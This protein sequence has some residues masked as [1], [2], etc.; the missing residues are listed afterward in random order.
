[1]SLYI[2]FD[3]I[4]Q[5][6]H[7][8][9]PKNLILFLNFIFGTESKK[10]QFFWN[11]IGCWAHTNTVDLSRWRINLRSIPLVFSKRQRR[12]GDLNQYYWKFSDFV[13]NCWNLESK[14][15]VQNHGSFAGLMPVLEFHSTKWIRVNDSQL[16][17]LRSEER[18]MLLLFS[19][20]QKPQT[21]FGN[22]LHGN[23][24]ACHLDIP[25]KSKVWHLLF[26]IVKDIF[27]QTKPQAAFPPSRFQSTAF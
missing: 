23:T 2:S 25:T 5:T 13:L 22:F 4:C 1:M 27:L 18:H 7:Q 8:I 24:S 10:I 16:L 20:P 11:L 19:W 26:L 9:E 15:C 3:L 12:K 6:G 17:N 14:N 21:Q